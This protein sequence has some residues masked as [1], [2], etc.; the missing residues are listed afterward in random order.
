MDED[1]VTVEVELPRETVEALSEQGSPEALLA[2]LVEDEARM[3]DAIATYVDGRDG[4]D[5]TA[6][7]ASLA[8]QPP[9]VGLLVGFEGIEV[10][11]GRAVV[12][13]DAGPR[14]AN[15]MGTLHG[16]V[17]CDVGDA[18]MGVAFASTLEEGESFT[19]LELD[20]KF[21]KP[22][23]EGRLEATGTVVK[24]GRTVGLVECDVTDEDG[25][26]VAHLQSV[27]LV[28]RGERATGR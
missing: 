13:L 17:L 6:P 25:S 3:L 1:A 8:E 24:R 7:S 14:H 19:T 18:A 23:W 16:G 22:V 11:D 10:E 2:R 12:A 27:C 20:V 21:L 15:P 9:P 28:L 4:G 5:R 26:L